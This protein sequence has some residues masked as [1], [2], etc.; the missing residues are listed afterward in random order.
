MSLL[1]FLRILVARRAIVFTTLFTCLTVAVIV[2]QVL[3]PRYKATSRIILD[4]VKPDPVTGELMGT[5]FIRAYVRTQ[6]ELIKDYRTAGRVVDQLG[7]TTNPTLIAQYAVATEGQGTDMRRWLA[8]RV[9]DGTDAGLVDSSNI[10]EI[11]YTGTSADTAGRVAELLRTA[12]IDLSL[13]GRRE[14]A[15]RTAD[16]FREQTDKALRVLTT[17]ET[18][19]AEYA[20][21]SGIV[22]QPNNVDLES[23]KLAALSQ[24]TAIPMA[25]LGAAMPAPS[26]IQLDQVNQQ[27]AQAAATLGP[28][29]PVFQALQRSRVVL[30]AEVAR[31]NSVANSN[32]FAGASAAQIEGAY[33]Q[34]KSRVIAQRDEIDKLNQMQRDIM[35]KRDQYLKSAQRGAEFR[36]A[37]DVGETG[38][39]PLGQA[40]TPQAPVFPNVP[41]IILGSIGLGL[42]LGLCIALLVEML[43]RRVRSDD[44]LETAAKAPVFAIIGDR[45]NPDGWVRKLLRLIDRKGRARPEVAAR[46]AYS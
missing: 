28:N 15:T 2:S 4:I 35:L 41:L 24:Q 38:M 7:W 14:S 5:H 46:E 27:I 19:L 29:H 11:S 1:Q 6:I 17:A 42:G 21:A 32:I 20:K 36:L 26:Q 16:W 33:Q 39:T 8:Q 31:Q 23:A 45:R 34:Q 25:P 22:L 37:A 43:G 10:L 18:A 3:P 12:Y 40:T 9:I 44:D 13:E 30:E